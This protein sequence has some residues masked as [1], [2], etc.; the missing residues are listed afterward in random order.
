M[1]K[2]SGSYEEGDITVLSVWWEEGGS[3]QCS[4]PAAVMR[5][6]PQPSWRSGGR[7]RAGG[8]CAGGFTPVP[9]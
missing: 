6:V 7:E 8:G 2:A 4:G 3:A 5:K 1:F 9:H